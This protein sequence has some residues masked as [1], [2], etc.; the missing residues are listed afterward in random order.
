MKISKE[1]VEIK[2]IF[3]GVVPLI[4]TIMAEKQILPMYWPIIKDALVDDGG[5]QDHRI[6]EGLMVVLSSRC[7]NSYCF[8][9]HS[10]FLYGLGFTVKTIKSLVDELKFPNQV[11]DNEKWS[12]VLKWSFLVGRTSVGPS[13]ATIDSSKFIRELINSD[14]YRHVFKIYTV[15][16]M[17]NRFSEFYS[18]EIRVEKEAMFHDSSAK[19]RLPIPELSKYYEKVLQSEVNA[20]RPVVAICSYCKNIRDTEGKWHALETVLPSLE[21]DSTFSHGV[22]PDCYKKTMNEID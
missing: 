13:G 8:V 11:D 1:I 15:I 21:R 14:E 20:E 9:S 12:L 2:D 18:E 16:D 4:F 7:E 17:L 19:L 10:Y 22:C 3:H 5:I 6:K